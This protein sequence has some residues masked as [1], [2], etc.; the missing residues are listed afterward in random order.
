MVTMFYFILST[1]SISSY[2][3]AEASKNYDRNDDEQQLLDLLEHI[4][5]PV[6]ISFIIGLNG[7]CHFL[8]TSEVPLYAYPV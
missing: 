2:R 8:I 5:I 1:H 4:Q 3:R 7:G 6:K